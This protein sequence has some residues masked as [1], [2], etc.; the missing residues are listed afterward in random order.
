[1]KAEPNRV[2]PGD[3]QDAAKGA[4]MVRSNFLQLQALVSIVLAYQ[5]LLSPTS[6][7][8]HDFE[9]LIILGLMSAC[10]LIMVIP[11]RLLTT[12]WFPGALAVFDTAVTTTMMYGSGTAG[13]DLYLA[14]F[15]IIL[16]VT[17]TRTALTMTIF[18]ALVTVIYGFVLYQEVKATGQVLEHHLIRIPFLLIMAIF[19]RRTAETARMLTYYDQLTGLP[20]RRHFVRL[21]AQHLRSRLAGAR[22]SAILAVDLD[23]FKRIN[24]TLGHVMGDQL[25]KAAALRL[26]ES[27]RASDTIARFGADEFVILLQKVGSAETAGRL[28]ERLLTTLRRPF[29]IG[30]HEVFVTASIGIALTEPDAA[31]PGNLLKHA[32][33]AMYRAKER[34]KNTYEFYSPELNDRAYQRLVLE[35]RLHKAIERGEIVVHYQP[36]INFVTNEIIGVEALA[37]WKDPEAGLIPPGDFIPLAEETGLIVEIGTNVLR[38]ACVQLSAWHDAGFVPLRLAVNIS[39]KQFRDAHLVAKVSHV[40]KETKV[41][42]QNLEIE[43]TETS[44]MHDAEVAL[45]TLQELKTMGAQLSIDDFGT[46]YSSL[47]YLRR[48]PIDT[49]KIDRAFTHDLSASPD[50]Q[51]IV[52]AII[53]MAQSL[54][55]RVIAEGIETQ[56]QMDLLQRYGCHCGQGFAFSRPLPAEEVTAFLQQWSAAPRGEIGAVR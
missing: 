27:L 54:K 29:L 12:E 30:G 40:L 1:M 42:A 26:K 10:G 56:E 35:S 22:A 53:A 20:N 52:H 5:L 3:T 49:L 4:W 38:Q 19:Y 8:S 39:A 31:D 24:E 2:L 36:Q 18:L 23:G 55:L 51:A 47:V 11:L 9:L 16:I 13:S 6:K 33:A 48:F 15:V 28:A 7:P 50:A 45:K 43:L 32:D 14:F 34:G 46:G 44:I 17:A 21:A 41:A 25:L 37:R